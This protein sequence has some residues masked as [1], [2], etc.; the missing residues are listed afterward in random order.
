MLVLTV[1]SP[2]LSSLSG[3][4]M[5]ESWKTL[6]AQRIGIVFPSAPSGNTG[7]SD[8]MSS[9]SSHA[10][11]PCPLHSKIPQIYLRIKPMFGCKA[12]LLF[13]G[14]GVSALLLPSFASLVVEW[15]ELFLFHRS[16]S[17]ATVFCINTVF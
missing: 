16:S 1:S 5:P 14:S 2:L 15:G 7:K 10:E 6:R 12:V 9:V 8:I 3:S 4:S 13:R 11:Q 17:M